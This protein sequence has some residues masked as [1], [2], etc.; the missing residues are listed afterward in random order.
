MIITKDEMAKMIDHTLLK[1]AATVEEITELCRE[2]ALKGFASVCI[3][4]SYVPLAVKALYNSDVPV[5]T[6]I[7]FPLGATST[8]SKAFEAATAVREGAR[9]IDMVINV[10]FLKS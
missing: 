4:P 7:G 1:P 8:E 3:N 10:G 2:A 6:V 5:C 9:E